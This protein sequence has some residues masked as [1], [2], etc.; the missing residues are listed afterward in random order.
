MMGWEYGGVGVASRGVIEPFLGVHYENAYFHSANG[1]VGQ[2]FNGEIVADRKAYVGSAGMH[3]G[4]YD[5]IQGEKI[6]NRGDIVP[7]VGPYVTGDRIGAKVTMRFGGRREDDGGITMR[8]AAE[9]KDPKWWKLWE[10]GGNHNS[11][12][13][14]VQDQLHQMRT[15]RPGLEGI[16]V[17]DPYFEQKINQRW[18]GLGL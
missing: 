16:G 12:D 3:D 5:G 17:K 11:M 2:R 7:N 14:F 6:Q 4:W 15:P 13:Y 1:A 10:L 8:Q 9:V 18:G